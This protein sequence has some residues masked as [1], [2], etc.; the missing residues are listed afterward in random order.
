MSV[1]WLRP[2]LVIAVYGIGVLGGWP[3][4][5]AVCRGALPEGT[6]QEQPRTG[7]YI[8]FFERLIVLTLVALDQYQ[9]IAF[10]FAAKSIARFRKQIDVEYYLI[11][12]LAS[13]AWAL[14]WGLAL[15]WLM[16]S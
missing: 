13:L 14:A 10:I 6:V 9:A 11:G 7:V 1:I 5:W 12:T 8:G 2:L 16:A 4:V 15:A 3:F